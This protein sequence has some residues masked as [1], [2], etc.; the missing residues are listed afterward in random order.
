M[1]FHQVNILVIR[2]QKQ[3][4]DPCSTWKSP[5]SWPLSLPPAGTLA[6]LIVVTSLLLQTILSPLTHIPKHG[7]LVLPVFWTFNKENHTVCILQ[8]LASLAQPCSWNSGVFVAGSCCLFTFI[9]VYYCIEWLAQFLY[10][11][12]WWTF[13][14]FTVWDC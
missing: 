2:G 4:T 9:A 13:G 6:W 11:F 14:L 5:W 12:C 3:D 8:G 1:A 7:S 10:E